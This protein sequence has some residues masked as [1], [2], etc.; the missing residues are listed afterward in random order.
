MA[1]SQFV[2]VKSLIVMRLDKLD[3]VVAR[4]AGLDNHL[5]LFVGASGASRHLFQHVKGPLV[6]AEVREIDHG[7]GIEDAHNAHRVKVQSFGDHLRAH[8]NVG[9]ML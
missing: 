2:L 3:D 8:Q 1:V 7:V 5:P 4:L 9:A 6:T